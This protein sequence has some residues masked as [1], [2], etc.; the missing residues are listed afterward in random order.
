[1]QSVAAS[2][3]T[4]DVTKKSNKNEIVRMIFMTTLQMCGAL[5][6]DGVDY[7]YNRRL[8]FLFDYT[9]IRFIIVFIFVEMV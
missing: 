6:R 2:L 1:M 4:C 3:F 8:R 5:V 7:N 9:V